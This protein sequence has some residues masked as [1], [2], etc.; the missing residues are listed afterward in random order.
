MASLYGIDCTR[1]ANNIHETLHSTFCSIPSGWEE[2]AV[3]HLALS[4]AVLQ[5]GWKVRFLVWLNKSEIGMASSCGTDWTRS[6]ASFSETL[7]STICS[8]PSGWGVYWEENAVHHLACS[9][10]GLQTGYKV[11]F[12]VWSSPYGIDC[13]RSAG[14]IHETLHSMFCSILSG[15]E[16][17]AVH[18]LAPSLARLQNGWKVRFL[19]WLNKS[20]IGMAC[21]YGTDWTRSAASFSD[22]LLHTLWMRRILSRE[23]CALP[24]LLPNGTPK[25]MINP[26]FSLINKV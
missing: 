12:L 21:P 23:C 26:L 4:L 16:E 15:W 11:Q 3:H 6:A 1:S 19:V 17:N 2:N 5:N 10:A 24:C 25:W 13:T 14:N 20:E 9:L 8:I 7:H 18:H 22:T